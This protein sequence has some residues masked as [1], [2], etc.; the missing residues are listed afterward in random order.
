M[1]P[2]RALLDVLRPTAALLGAHIAVE[3]TINDRAVDPSGLD[4]TTCDLLL[5]ISMSPNGQLRAADLCRQLQLSPSYVS[6][7]LDRALAA[8]LVEREPDPADR[9]AHIITLT[10][11]GQAALDT[12]VP[13]LVDVVQHVVF[14]TL[15][16]EEVATLI[17]LLERV[18]SAALAFRSSAVVHR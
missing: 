7:R 4:A 12:F 15:E 5:R 16:D 17:D 6:R 9:R 2:T 13:Q 14:D 11:D 3:A 1:S 8:G 18:E 10:G